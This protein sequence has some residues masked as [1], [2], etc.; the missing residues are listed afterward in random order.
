[1]AKKIIVGVLLLLVFGFVGC[2]LYIRQNPLAVFTKVERSTLAKAQFAKKRVSSSAGDLVY[3]EK[4]TGPVLVFVHGAG[5]QAGTWSKVAP[6][7]ADSY[8]VIIPDLAGH[9]ES[10]PKSG[11]IS[12]GDEVKGLEALFGSLKIEKPILVGNS[13]GAWV[14]LLY[15]Y[16][17]PDSV[18][19]LV[20]VNGGPYAVNASYNLMPANREEA[21]TVMSSLQD[22]GSPTIPNFVLDDI[23]RR[24]HTGPIGRL[25]QAS[26]EQFT[27]DGKLANMKTPAD[28]LWGQADKMLGEKYAE[29]LQSELV[30]PRLTLLPRCGHIPQRE[31]P[32][33]FTSK[34]SEILKQKAPQLKASKPVLGASSAGAQD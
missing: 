18:D 5:D 34:L 4:G 32:I 3:W 25:V 26:Q 7:F 20:L 2:V 15:A 22:P 33:A 12:I 23:V 28:I 16:Q 27:L 24:S 10:D 11:P 1:M 21:R 6:A 14:S 31:C 9:G 30:A 8:R 17:H 13:M 19:R 29:R